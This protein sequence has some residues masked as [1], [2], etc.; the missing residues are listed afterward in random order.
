M[1]NVLE[2]DNYIYDYK[3]IIDKSD[4]LIIL[5]IWKEFKNIKDIT[6]KKVMD[7]THKI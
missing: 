5:T 2:D 1:Y 7:F 6:D 3:D 4:I